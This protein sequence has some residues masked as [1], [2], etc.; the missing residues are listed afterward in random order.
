MEILSEIKLL[1]GDLS[2][3]GD[4]EAE[5]VHVSTLFILLCWSS[6]SP[7]WVNPVPS[8]GN[9]SRNYTCQ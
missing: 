4:F 6:L 7:L 5:P 3:A 8:Q 9:C 2:E 1:L